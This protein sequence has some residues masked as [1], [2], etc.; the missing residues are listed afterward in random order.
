MSK[1]PM[2]APLLV[3]V[4][5][6]HDIKLRNIEDTLGVLRKLSASRASAYAWRG[7]LVLSVSG[8]DNDPRELAEIPS[9]RE[10]FAAI[11]A[12]WPYWLW[13]IARNHEQISLVQSLLTKVHAIIRRD[14]LL[15]LDFDKSSREKVWCELC[16][17]ME[18]GLGALGVAPDQ[19]AA[20]IASAEEELMLAAVQIG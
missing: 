18:I 3:C 1:Q 4:I 11:N 9:V 5:S 2:Q 8:Y 13:F 14:G 6:G 15:I 17:R 10:H 12:V 19:I 16:S 20:S 7:K